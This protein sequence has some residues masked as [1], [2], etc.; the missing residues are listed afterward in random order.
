MTIHWKKPAL[1][2]AIA[3]AAT[4]STLPAYAA[5]GDPALPVVSASTEAPPASALLAAS[6]AAPTP[7]DAKTPA[8]PAAS[9]DSANSPASNDS[10][11][12]AD[13]A[14]SAGPP[15]SADPAAADPTTPAARLLPPAPVGELILHLNSAAMEQGGKSYKAA[16]PLVVKKGVTYAALRALSDRIGASI[17]NDAKAKETIV[18]FGAAELRLKAG[19]AV[20]RLNGVQG[21][22][23]GAA[24]DDRGA[25][26]VPLVSFAQALKIPY[27]VLSKE[28]QIVLKPQLKPTAS[29]TIQKGEIVAGETQIVYETQAK[30]P[31][32]LAIADERWEG[33][34][35]VFAEPGS[36]KVSYSVQDAAGVWS[37]P[38]AL[39]IR[40]VAPNIPPVAQFATD[41]DTYRMGEP[42]AFTDTSSDADGQ[43]VSRQWTNNRMA[44]F[45]P[46]DVTVQ[47]TVTDDRGG[48]SEYSKTLTITNETLYARDEFNKL[49]T[50][51][52]A[53]YAIDGS[54][55]RNLEAL[56]YTYT[57]EPTTLFRSSGPESVTTDG[58]L[59][60]D[61]I[62]GNTRFMLHHKNKTGRDAKLYLIAKNPGSAEAH[63]QATADG[64]AG[65]SPF[66]EVAGRMSVARFFDSKAAGGMPKTLALAPGESK[67]IYADLSAKPMK[68]DDIITFH[69]EVESDSAIQYSAVLVEASRDPIA[70]LAS[71]PPLDPNQSIVRGTFADATRVFDYAEVVGARPAK[72]SL[73]DNAADPFQ[74]GTDGMKGTPALNSGNYGVLYKVV[75]RHVAPR[76]L[77]SFNPRGGLFAGAALVNGKTVSFAHLGMSEATN[78]ASVLYR[79]GDAEETV[80]I[81]ITPA[82]GS[83]LPFC[84]LFT[85][86]PALRT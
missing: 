40:V 69:G 11:P 84:L 27:T 82:A 70:A 6:S 5:P 58:I 43:I 51:T 25:L 68:Q 7:A 21:K 55:V 62:A 36:Y 28:K 59:Y 42:I 13:P 53:N 12:S 66:P 18:R 47:L 19:S 41:K 67:L 44:F 8:E 22:L 75:L 10:T 23:A 78:Q 64:M 9:S 74:Q 39:T 83:N 72:L 34:Q 30:S 85:P 2:A 65:P 17:Q 76:T 29:F 71:L 80:E 35:D 15:A 48:V 50:P 56:P 1:A 73:T 4:T 52:G 26:M 54:A 14:S 60:Q 31:N 37:D 20:Y 77:I 63:L 57:T 61:T 46:G 16:R 49:F 24:Y 3:L 86:L 45:E 81:Q 33:R 32:G 79:T 38:Y